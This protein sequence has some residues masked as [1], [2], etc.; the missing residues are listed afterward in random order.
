MDAFLFFI[1]FCCVTLAFFGF[2]CVGR[3]LFTRASNENL[4]LSEAASRIAGTHLGRIRFLFVSGVVWLVLVIIFP[5]PPLLYSPEAYDALRSA[6]SHFLYGNR[7]RWM[8]DT[9]RGQ[10]GALIKHSWAPKE[11]TARRAL[12]VAR[13]PFSKRSADP[14]LEVRA[15]SLLPSDVPPG[16]PDTG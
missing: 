15:T 10:A 3:S 11:P 2:A 12:T 1:K 9:A 4:T 6:W 7:S 8:F 14:L 5:G 16:F 13:C